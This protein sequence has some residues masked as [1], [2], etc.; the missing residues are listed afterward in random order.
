VGSGRV[1]RPTLIDILRVADHKIVSPATAADVEINSFNIWFPIKIENR[2]AERCAPPQRFVMLGAQIGKLLHK[3]ADNHSMWDHIAD[4]GIVFFSKLLGALY[5]QSLLFK[6]VVYLLRHSKR[7]Q[8]TV[9]PL[10]E[11]AGTAA[12]KER[13]RRPLSYR[14]ITPREICHAGINVL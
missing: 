7:P 14:A 8:T 3:V 9:F 4:R 13:H 10:R 2:H 5:R 6:L 12:I 11:A 1:T